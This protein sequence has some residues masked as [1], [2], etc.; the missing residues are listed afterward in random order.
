MFGRMGLHGTIKTLAK[1]EALEIMNL[2]SIGHNADSIESASCFKFGFNPDGSWSSVAAEKCFDTRN[3]P[4][5]CFC[6]RPV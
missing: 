5:D 3:Q 1:V 6:K 4:T 2:I